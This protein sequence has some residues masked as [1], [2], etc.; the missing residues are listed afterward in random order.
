MSLAVKNASGSTVNLK[1]TTDG[2]DEVPH[3]IMEYP[4][5]SSFRNVS[6]VNSTAVAVKASAGELWGF[7]IINLHTADIFVKLYNVAAGSVNPASDVPVVTLQVPAL[8]SVFC[9]PRC[10]VHDFATAIAVRAVTGS[11]D[12]NTTAPGTVPIVELKY[13]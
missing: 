1:T 11:G 4:A 10:I 3:H 9:E 13:V 8:G 6:S 2:S 7:N 12:T 5:Q